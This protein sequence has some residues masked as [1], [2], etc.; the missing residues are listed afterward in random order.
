MARRQA[1]EIE[2]RKV[3]IRVYQSNGRFNARFPKATGGRHRL[4]RGTEWQAFEAAK[5]LIDEM[6]DPERQA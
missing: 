1:S 2:Y 4:E 5:E 6:K 3:R